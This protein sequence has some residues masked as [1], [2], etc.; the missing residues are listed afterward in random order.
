[1]V[2]KRL[3]SVLLA[4]AVISAVPITASAASVY[5]EGNISTTYVTYFEDILGKLSPFDD[6]VFFR[7]GQYEYTM[8]VGDLTYSN[9]WITSNTE[10]DI[11]QIYS[12]TSGYNNVYQMR[13]SNS[14]GY[15]LEAGDS[16]V[17]SNLGGYPDL[18]ERSDYIE[19]AVLLLVLVAVFMSLIARIFSFNLR[20]SRR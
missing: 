13:F 11:Y 17:Y 3:I 14:I 12:T 15:A 6:Y 18:T 9:G 1:M 10:C 5:Q 16:L 2:W 4:L 19:T 8:C 20:T 7:S